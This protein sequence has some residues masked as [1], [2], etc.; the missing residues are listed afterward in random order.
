MDDNVID[1]AALRR[2][3]EVIGGAADDLDEL[4][5]DYLDEAPSMAA[6][7]GAAASAGDVNALRIAAH[8]LKSSARDFGAL[9]LSELCAALELECRTGT[10]S[11]LCGRAEAI[12]VAE[13]AARKA[14]S[15]LNASDL[16]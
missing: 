6:Q 5:A 16:F 12:A 15:K 8:T 9:G 7:I 11:D 13:L 2:L 4:L 3:L 1:R 14:L 10:V